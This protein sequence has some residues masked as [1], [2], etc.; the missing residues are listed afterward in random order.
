M[1]I[2]DIKTDHDNNNHDKAAPNMTKKIAA[3][4]IR[5]MKSPYLHYDKLLKTLVVLSHARATS[6]TGQTIIATVLIQAI[7]RST[8]SSRQF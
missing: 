1:Q 2:F 6:N 8:Q 3:L 7:I 5:R 4:E